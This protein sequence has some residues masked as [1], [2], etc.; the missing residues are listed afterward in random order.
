MEGAKV[1]QNN[2]ASVKSIIAGSAHHL[3]TPEMVCNLQDVSNFEYEDF[4]LPL[5]PSI[6]DVAKA[7]LSAALDYSEE[8]FRVE[9]LDHDWT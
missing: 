3:H 6:R 7:L 2:Y 5:L 4:L 9:V 8:V 1:W